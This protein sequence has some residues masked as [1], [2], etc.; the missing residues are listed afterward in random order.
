MFRFLWRRGSVGKFFVVLG[1]AELLQSAAS[2]SFCGWDVFGNYALRSAG[3]R[4]LG[5]RVWHHN[6]SHPAYQ[7]GAIAALCK[8]STPAQAKN[9]P[10]EHPPKTKRIKSLPCKGGCSWGKFGVG[11]G[12]LEGRE[13]PP[14]G[15]SLRLQ[16]L[17][18][19]PPELALNRDVYKLFTRKFAKAL[20]KTPEK[21]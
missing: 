21:W 9:F 16:G 15:G 5:T 3:R 19:F 13:T 14:K 12:G 2:R 7:S 6:K 10:Q 1:G 8:E 17:P 20:D 4:D 18:R 11:Q